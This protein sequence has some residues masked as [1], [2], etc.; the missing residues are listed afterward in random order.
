MKKVLQVPWILL[1]NDNDIRPAKLRS[2]GLVWKRLGFRGPVWSGF[3]PSWAWTETGTGLYTLGNCYK[4]DRNCTKPV[5]CGSVRSNHR[6][7]PTFCI[8]FY[9]ANTLLKY[10]YIECASTEKLRAR[11]RWIGCI[12]GSSVTATS[13][14]ALYASCVVD[15]ARRCWCGRCCASLMRPVVV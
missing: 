8:Y 11:P 14:A 15:I 13:E 1:N 3:L 2:W 6:F 4:P 10:I 12:G 9:I 5:L 7:G